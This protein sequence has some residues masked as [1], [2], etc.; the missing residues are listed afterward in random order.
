[1]QELIYYING[2]YVKGIFGCFVDV[3]NLVMGEVQVKVF[4][5]N[6]DEFDVVVEIVVVV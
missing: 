3:F 2:E 4:L 1:M 5:V 6:K